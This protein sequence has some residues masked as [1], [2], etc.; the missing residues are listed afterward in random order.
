MAVSAGERGLELV[1]HRRQ[2]A[3]LE[4][5]GLALG[6]GRR[7]RRLEALAFEEGADE[8]GEG[9]DQADGVG[10][11]RHAVRPGLDG[12]HAGHAGGAAITAYSPP[13]S[14]VATVAAASPERSRHFAPT[15]RRRS[16][17]RAWLR[18]RRASRTRGLAAQAQ[19][20]T[21][22]HGERRRLRR[23]STLMI[24]LRQ[25]SV[26]CSVEVWEATAA[27]SRLSA[28]V[29]CSRAIARASRSRKRPVWRPTSRPTT[30]K[31]TSESQSF[32]SCTSNV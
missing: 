4:P 14:P 16:G 32:G 5:V 12:E 3:R 6:G 11:V 17:G 25:V 15:R 28:A 8:V 19:V 10:R 18:P 26:I 21:L 22:P 13:S 29:S 24:S 31:A 9:R 2:Q 27:L 7:G 30:R 1:R 23:P 20:V